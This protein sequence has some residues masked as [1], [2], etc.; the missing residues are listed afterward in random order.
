MLESGAY[1]FI[2][3]G[4]LGP[5][6]STCG[7]SSSFGPR[8]Q[9]ST[10][11]LIGGRVPGL[12]VS[13]GSGRSH[14]DLSCEVLLFQFQK[15]ESPESSGAGAWGGDEQSPAPPLRGLPCPWVPA[16]PPPSQWRAFTCFQAGGGGA[17]A[18][19]APVPGAAS[20][21]HR[22]CAPA[23]TSLRL[24][25]PEPRDPGTQYP[26]P[27]DPEPS[28]GSLLQGSGLLGPPW[29]PSRSQHR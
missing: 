16:C 25:R 15:Q 8:T 24:G 23:R 7:L 2:T 9:R 5:P 28:V 21:S 22:R 10:S 4:V 17:G 6:A 18:G 29:P 14:L 12:K 13:R 11:G 19:C 27:N 20:V 26:R 3:T 1:N